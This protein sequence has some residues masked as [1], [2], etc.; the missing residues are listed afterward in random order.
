MSFIVGLAVENHNWVAEIKAY[1]TTDWVGL[2]LAQVWDWHDKKVKLSSTKNAHMTDESLP[3]MA[4]LCV[5][6]CKQDQG[7]ADQVPRKAG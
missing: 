4:A 7:Y 1:E 2:I 6:V 5:C 3:F